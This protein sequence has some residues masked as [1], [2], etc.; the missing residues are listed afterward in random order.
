LL[1]NGTTAMGV[2]ARDR[3]ARL[4]SGKMVNL[5]FCELRASRLI[6]RQTTLLMTRAITPVV[7]QLPSTPLRL[8]VQDRL[9]MPPSTRLLESVELAEQ[10]P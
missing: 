7:V 2:P 4:P 5:V 10:P 8:L 9:A 1:K 6:T 3:M